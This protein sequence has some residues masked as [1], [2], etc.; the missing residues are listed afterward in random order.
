M[1]LKRLLIVVPPVAQPLIA[2]SW[3]TFQLTWVPIA[4]TVA[5]AAAIPLLLMLFFKFFPILSI[6]EIEELAAE[7]PPAPLDVGSVGG[8]E[9]GGM[10]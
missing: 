4:I 7:R 6:Y 9:R 8:A 5:G 10:R 1:W 3:G 2:G